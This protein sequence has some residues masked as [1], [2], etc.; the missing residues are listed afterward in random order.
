MKKWKRNLLIIFVIGLI[1][2][3][4]VFYIATKKPASGVE[5]KPL[6]TMKASELISSLDSNPVLINKKYMF[7]NIAI[8]GKIKEI[9][10]K[11]SNVIIDAGNMAIVNCSFDSLA[12]VKSIPF[13]KMGEEVNVKGIYYGCD[14]FEEKTADD[15]ELLPS[16]KTAML[17]T[18]GINK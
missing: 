10:V 5:S 2:S 17:R 15:L 16:E 18:C 6:V 13:L 14:G 9:N 7:K 12:F 4:Y 1:A 3:L 11:G 8:S